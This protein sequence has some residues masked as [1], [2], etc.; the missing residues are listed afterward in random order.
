MKIVYIIALVLLTAGRIAAQEAVAKAPTVAT[1]PAFRILSESTVPQPD[2]G[3]VTFQRV[4]PPVVMQQ[5]QPP[6]NPA[7]PALTTVQ[8]DA[9][10]QVA[11][12]EVKLLSISASVKANG[13]TVLRWTCGASQRFQA[14][15]SVDFRYLEG[16]GSLEMAQA[17]YLLIL[18][19]GPDEQ[20]MTD[21]ETRAAQSLP[22]NGIASFALLSGSAATGPADESALD[23]MNSLLDYFA[24]HREELVKLHAKRE[25]DSAARELAARNAPPPPPRHSVIHYWP[26]QPAQRAAINA[27]VQQEV[28]RQ[29]NGG[30]QP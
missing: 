1:P 9:G 18:S 26:L 15:S 11:L 13:F 4:A 7:A 20:S 21:V 29:M 3:T 14:V 23:A 2:G 25:A 5:A 10:S 8:A 16:L 24:A 27:Q 17:T 19:A 30:K 28:Q 22:L 12:K 6:V